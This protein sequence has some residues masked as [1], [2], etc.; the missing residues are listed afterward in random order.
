MSEIIEK[1]PE[2]THPEFEITKGEL[3]FHHAMARTIDDLLSQRSCSL[4]FGVKITSES[5]GSIAQKMSI[6]L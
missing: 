2:L 6:L 3:F 1:Y 4:I 5:S